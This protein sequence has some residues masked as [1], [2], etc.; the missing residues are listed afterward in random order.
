MQLAVRQG[1]ERDY[2]MRGS[3]VVGSERE[4][5]VK[6][7]ALRMDT[8]VWRLRASRRSSLHPAGIELHDV[9]LRSNKG[10]V[11]YV[12]GTLPTRGEREPRARRAELPDRGRRRV[13]A[14]RL[15]AARHPRPRA[16]V[17]EGTTRDPRFR[18]A[19]GARQRQLQRLDDPELSS[20]RSS[21]RT[22][23]SRRTSRRLR[24]TGAAHGRRGRDAPDQSRVLRRHG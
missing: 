16:D 14:E 1:D 19:A 3:F 18:G 17:L 9:E 24:Q 4:V 8:T 13:P 20:R 5:R 15:S 7:L 22:R 10:G 12:N 6:D 21:T 23:R 11:V 2:S